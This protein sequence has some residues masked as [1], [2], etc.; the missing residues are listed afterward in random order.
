MSVCSQLKHFSAN[1][2]GFFEGPEKLLEIWF[3]IVSE[4]SNG[5][6]NIPR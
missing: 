3:D 4:E 6:R 5:L 2:V 1:E